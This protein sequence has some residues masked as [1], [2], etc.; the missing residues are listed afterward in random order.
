[1]VDYFKL[2]CKACENHRREVI[3]SVHF[4]KLK[5]R[6]VKAF[7]Y[8]DLLVEYN[9]KYIIYSNIFSINWYTPKNHIY[10]FPPKKHF[11]NLCITHLHV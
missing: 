6:V 2:K 7:S 10:V 9:T 4:R 3:A 8:L 11:C 5:K 1:M